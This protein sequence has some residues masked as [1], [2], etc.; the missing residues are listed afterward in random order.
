MAWSCS[1]PREPATLLPC[2]PCR[3]CCQNVSIV[4]TDEEREWL[5]KTDQTLADPAASRSAWRLT[6]KSN[7]DCVYLD[8]AAGCVIYETRPQTC[9]EFSCLEE[10]RR[11]RSLNEWARRSGEA[12]ANGGRGVALCQ[13]PRISPS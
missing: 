5:P 1:F 12:I 8:P 13:A 3:A 4:L 9:R 11:G 2:G 10:W 6:R 7:G